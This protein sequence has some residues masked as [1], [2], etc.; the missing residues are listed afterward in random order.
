[1]AGDSMAHNPDVAAD[2]FIERG[3]HEKHP[4]THI[5]VQKLLYSA[6][7]WMLGIHE[8]PFIGGGAPYWITSK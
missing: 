4:L 5:E 1:M 3:I 8:R 7:G 2:W 6:N